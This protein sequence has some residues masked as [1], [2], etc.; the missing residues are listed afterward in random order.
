MLR[1]IDDLE[2]VKVHMI[3]NETLFHLF[4]VLSANGNAAHLVG[5]RELNR[6][7]HMAY[8]AL[9]IWYEGYGLTTE[10]EEDVRARLDKLNLSTKNSGS[11]YINKFLQYK[12]KVERN[13]RVI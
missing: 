12:K 9:I 3:D 1:V 7:R 2:Y 5:A 8:K 11:T 13:R 10:T 6:Y 4:Q